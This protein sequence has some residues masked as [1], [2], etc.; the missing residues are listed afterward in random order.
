[1]GAAPAEVFTIKARVGLN[2]QKAPS[3]AITGFGTGKRSGSSPKENGLFVLSKS[4]VDGAGAQWEDTRYYQDSK[5]F[6]SLSLVDT[7]ACWRTSRPSKPPEL[8][9]QDSAIGDRGGFIISRG[10]PDASEGGWEALP[11]LLDELPVQPVSLAVDAAYNAGQL[12]D[13]WEQRGITVYIP[14]HPK[15]ES[16][17]VARRGFEHRGDHVVSSQGKVLKRA[18]YHRRNASYQDVTSQKDCQACPIKEQ[19]LPPHQKR[20]CLALTI[21][22]PLT[23]KSRNGTKPPPTGEKWRGVGPLS[24]ESLRLGPAGMG[25]VAAER[26]VEEPGPEESGVEC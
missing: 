11:R 14:I 21:Y 6:L 22:Y 25:K 3:Q 1:M 2:H 19:C 15:W 5:G 8:N 20:R 18:G 23:F 9:Y 16:N 12:R 13:L 4:S 7:D 17:M 24:R 10:G 26:I